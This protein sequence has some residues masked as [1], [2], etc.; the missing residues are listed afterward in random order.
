MYSPPPEYGVHGQVHGQ[1]TAKLR[2]LHLLTD[3]QP[4]FSVKKPLLI[5][6]LALFLTLAPCARSC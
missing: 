4:F 5:L 6:L 1:V 2:P 3:I